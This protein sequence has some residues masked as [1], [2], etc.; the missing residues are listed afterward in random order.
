MTD[1]QDSPKPLDSATVAAYLRLHPRVRYLFGAVSISAALPIE[2]REQ[3]VAYYAQFYGA[4]EIEAVSKRPFVY[5]AAPPQ[6][7]ELDADTS[8]RVLKANLDALGATVPMQLAVDATVCY[9]VW[10]V[11][12]LI[13]CLI[14]LWSPPPV[15]Q[16]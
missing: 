8:F 13:G 3:I 12:A 7:G 5:R 1:Q 10:P 2:A 4:Q 9:L 16:T 14:V 11:T 6:F 15:D